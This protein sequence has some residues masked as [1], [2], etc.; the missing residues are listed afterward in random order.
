MVLFLVAS[1]LS[2]IFGVLGVLNFAHG[3]LYMLGAYFTYTL[4][5]AHGNF[6]VTVILASIGVGV[7]GVI[8]E[9]LF[10]KRIYASPLL[11]QLLLCYAFILILDDLV[12]LIWGYEF[13]NIGVPNPFRRPPLHFFGS[14]M[15]S[16]YLFII[17]V[18]GI[19]ALTLWLVLSRSR[20]GKII[21]AT[22]HSSEMVGALGINVNLVYAGVFGL[23]SI[24]TGLGG[25]LAGPVRSI[26]PGMGAS[27]IIE[28]FIVVVIGGLGSIGGAFIGAILIGLMRS[29]GIIGFPLIE[30][31]FVFILMAVVLIFRPRG[32]FGKKEA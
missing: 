14:F 8:F 20:F 30:E 28:S 11:Y 25:V 7:F 18:G 13:K 1:G 15:P 21:R 12:K 16:Y 26:Y 9:R 5:G 29:F 17:I 3:S 23:G 31:S 2:L 6:G 19:V 27:V 32:L 22:A 4:L 24:L 10:I